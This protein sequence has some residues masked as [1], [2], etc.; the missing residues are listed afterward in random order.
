MVPD[1]GPLKGTP[2]IPY[3]KTQGQILQNPLKEVRDK[4]YPRVGSGPGYHELGVLGWE[5]QDTD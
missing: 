5:C 2:Y 4:G 1:Y 3:N